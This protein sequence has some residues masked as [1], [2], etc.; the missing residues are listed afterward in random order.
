MAFTRRYEFGY[1]TPTQVADPDTGN[2]VTAQV[3]TTFALSGVSED[4]A[5]GIRFGLRKVPTITN[6]TVE[7][8]METKEGVTGDPA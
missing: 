8:V 5:K 3:P 7:R 2:P 6:V 4:V 1:T